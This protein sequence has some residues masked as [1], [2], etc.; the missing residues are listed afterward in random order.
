[1]TTKKKTISKSVGTTK[2]KFVIYDSFNNSIFV[3]ES[4]EKAQERLS[5]WP[6]DRPGD[7]GDTMI[8]EVS[9]IYRPIRQ[10]VKLEELTEPQ[11]PKYFDNE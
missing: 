7:I 5:N 1:M 3:E 11:I 2:P 6:S 10:Q 8:F 4:F 9:R